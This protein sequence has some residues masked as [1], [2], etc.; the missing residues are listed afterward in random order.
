MIFFQK[1]L[2][3]LDF[4]EDLEQFIPFR[5]DI[6][7][8]RMLPQLDASDR[9]A[10]RSLRR[11][12]ADRFHYEYHVVLE[13]LKNDFV[14][15][16]PDRETLAEPD[17]SREEL[18][19]RRT[20]L[21]TSLRDILQTGN[22]RE[23]T[24]E[25]LTECLR[26]QPVGG[27]SVHVDTRDFDGFHVYYRGIRKRQETAGKYF[28]F[29]KRNRSMMFL[30]RVFVIAKFKEEHGGQV[31]IKMFKDVAVENIKIIAPKVRLG[32]PVFDRLKIGG[33]VIG[34]L[35]APVSK[36]IFAFTL[37][38]VYFFVILGGL[39]LA[40]FKGMMS[41]LNSRNKYMQRFSSSLYY[42]NLSNNNAA[43]TTLLDAAEN[44]ELK[45]MLL[46][47]FL[48]Y[49]HRE[50][51]MT[52]QE[53]DAAVEQWIA[54][55]FGHRLNFEVDDA[56]RKLVQKGIVSVSREISHSS[57]SA[58]GHEVYQALGLAESLRRLDT[59]WDHFNNYNHCSQ[60]K[61]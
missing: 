59:D 3:A 9:P 27:L 57:D 44:Q 36:L 52:M 41:F 45:E 58:D 31:L 25:Q 32:M 48:L 54:V 15:F 8:E 33:S 37:S 4:L 11:L 17:Y 18:Q 13:S 12:L 5:T 20:R 2:P 55:Q 22:Y 43:I 28:F 16:D 1:H 56:V 40:A 29:R 30:N 6:L 34:S 14:P 39:L 19:T 47:Y 26:M 10:F 21:S 60:D 61:V 51:T 23:L 42:R 49:L 53:L 46:G 7:L 50:R 24:P 35:I 38:W